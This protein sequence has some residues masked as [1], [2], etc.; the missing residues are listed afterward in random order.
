MPVLKLRGKGKEEY[1]HQGLCSYRIYLYLKHKAREHD[2]N[3][4]FASRVLPLIGSEDKDE[5]W[6]LGLIAELG[7]S[8]FN[9]ISRKWCICFMRPG[10][11]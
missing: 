3:H 2:Q 7:G 8:R 11:P 6:A 4:T 10:L 1:G 9:N 5:G